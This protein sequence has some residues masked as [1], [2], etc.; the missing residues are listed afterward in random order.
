MSSF[1]I[2]VLNVTFL[3]LSVHQPNFHAANRKRILL[4]LAG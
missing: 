2:L 3:I 4:S 1:I